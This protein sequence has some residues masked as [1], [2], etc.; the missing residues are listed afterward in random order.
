VVNKQ[1]IETVVLEKT[2]GQWRVTSAAV[3]GNWELGTG[4]WL[5]ATRN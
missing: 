2:A 1:E 5:L 4:N 3:T